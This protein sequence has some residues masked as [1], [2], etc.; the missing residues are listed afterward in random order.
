M[1]IIDLFTLTRRPACCAKAAG[2]ILVLLAAG[3]AVT[4]PEPEAEPAQPAFAEPA[5]AE[6]LPPPVEPPLPSITIAAVGDVMIGTNYPLNHL[7]DDDGLGFLSAVAPTLK[8]AD[9]VFGNLEG[10]LIDNGA[11]AKQCSDLSRCYVFRSP[12]RYASHLNDAGFDVLSLANNHGLDF[13]EHGRSETM[14]ALNRAGIR[15]S[16]RIGDIASWQTGRRT[17][18]MIAFSPTRCSYSLLDIEAAGRLVARLAESHDTVIVSF[19]GG[20]EGLDADHVVPGEEEYLGEK[21]GDLIGFSHHVIDAGADLVI[22]HGPHIPRA[23][24]IYN[25]RLIAYSLGNFATYYGIS[26]QGRKGYAP[27]LIAELDEAGRFIGGRIKSAIQL[28]P[29]GPQP[30]PEQ[31]AFRMMRRL[32]L[33]DFPETAPLFENDGTIKPRH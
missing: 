30:D 31:R 22:G 9:V 4:A 28:R 23:L 12:T 27:I 3:C 33:E 32:S 5:P 15:H 25:D 24:E 18:A 6:P 7:P 20:A 11:P 26:V 14:H 29:G 2:A 13:G 10:T 17:M 1:R 21:R 19:H 8:A 16:G